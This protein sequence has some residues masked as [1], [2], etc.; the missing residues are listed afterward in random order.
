MKN[1]TEDSFKYFRF[2]F[3]KVLI[4][5]IFKFFIHWFYVF[6]LSKFREFRITNSQNF[7]FK[8]GFDISYNP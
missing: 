7:G 1:I 2:S 3:P 8:G 4:E 6:F 5:I